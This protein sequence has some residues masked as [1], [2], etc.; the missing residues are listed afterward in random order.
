MLS[1]K[2][3][4]ALAILF[5]IIC[6]IFDRFALFDTFSFPQQYSLSQTLTVRFFSFSFSYLGSHKYHKYCMISLYSNQKLY[7]IIRFGL[8]LAQK[9]MLRFAKCNIY[10]NP[11]LYVC[12][13]NA[14]AKPRRINNPAL[15]IGY[16]RSE[17]VRQGLRV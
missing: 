16:F 10:P 6:V 5:A 8:L 1:G 3:Y 4:S 13:R 9:K 12:I 17:I 14:G 2:C 15:Q 11:E 7:W